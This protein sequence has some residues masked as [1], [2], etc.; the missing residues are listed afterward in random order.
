MGM[1]IHMNCKM[2]YNGD[3][4]ADTNLYRYISL[5]QFISFI[6]LEQIYL[7]NITKWEDTWEA[8]MRNI[9]TK[10]STGKLEKPLF[11]LEDTLYAQCW[12]KLKDSDALWRIYCKKNDGIMLKTSAK[13]FELIEGFRKAFLAEVIYFK[14]NDLMQQIMKLESGT[15]YRAIGGACLKR[16]SFTHES[17]VRF[18]VCQQDHF[19]NFKFGCEK[20]NFKVNVF[21][22]IED[23]YI[24]PRSDNWF[25]ESIKEYCK[26]R[27]FN[28]IPKKS[29]LYSNNIYEK[30]PFYIEYIPIEKE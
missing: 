13:K 5:S 20:L 25:V 26:R 8:P 14:E 22:F 28:I 1:G 6:E 15:E 30:N 17:E 24:D 16:D 29:D 2:F 18:I 19:D 21:D 27:G 4:N 3:V 9:P 10:S 11:R 7:T 12:S 23:I